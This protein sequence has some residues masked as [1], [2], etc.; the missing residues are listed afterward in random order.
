VIAQHL[1]DAAQTWG[2]YSIIAIAF[3]LASLSCRHF[4]FAA[5]IPFVGVPLVASTYDSTLGIGA[6]MGLGLAS[7]Y[8]LGVF[9]H[10]ASAALGRAGAGEGQLLIISLAALAIGENVL[11]LTN[12]G[13]SRNLLPLAADGLLHLGS[14]TTTLPRVSVLCVG[15]TVVFLH[16]T[17]WHYTG[18]GRAVRGLHESPLNMS[19]SGYNVPRLEGTLA[20]WAFLLAAVGGILWATTARVRTSMSLDVAAIGIATGIVAPLLARGALG[21]LLASAALALLKLLLALWF[22]GD[23]TTT[24][25]ILL[26]VISVLFQRIAAYGRG[27]ALIPPLAG[28]ADRS[29]ALQ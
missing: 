2:I 22:P 14:I 20:A 17:A 1:F 27:R 10:Q 12:G 3:Y 29:P 23:W 16:L 28:R 18:I 8:G 5:V 24:S 13:A 25:V 26:L 9:Y 19:L 21:L 7:A 4:N 6:G 11:L 15:S